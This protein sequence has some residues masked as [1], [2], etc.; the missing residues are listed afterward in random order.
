V[1][2]FQPWK[3]CIN[4]FIELVPNQNSFS[5]FDRWLRHPEYNVLAEVSETPHS[6]DP[7]NPDSI[8]LICSLYDDLLPNFSSKQFNVG[9]D[10]TAQLGEG[11]SSNA[12]AKLG[13]GRVYLNFLK[14][15]QNHVQ[16]KGRTMQF[17][18]DIVLKYPELIP[19]LPTNVIGLIW[20]YEANSPYE[21]RT[22][23]FADAGIAFYVCPGTAAWNSLLGRTDMMR[24]NVN[25]AA[26]YGLQNGAK[27]LMMT[28]WGDHGHWQT[29][30]F[31]YPGFTYAAALSWNFENNK[32]IDLPLALDTHIF[33]DENNVV[34]NIIAELGKVYHIA[35]TKIRYLPTAVLFLYYYQQEADL[36]DD[37]MQPDFVKKLQK[38]I[39]K[40]DVLTAELDNAKM[41]S[42]DGNL[43]IDEI[44]IDAAIAKHSYK[45]GIARIETQSTKI[46]DIPYERRKILAKELEKIIPEYRK[47]WLRRNREGGLKDSTSVFDNLLK[48]YKK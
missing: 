9:C 26:K 3:L 38:S 18:C 4:L 14:K 47:I 40:I 13:K 19:E 30:P 17:W 41:A 27:G 29:L 7:E 22:K 16:K 33:M 23:K 43:I 34:G 20:G 12:V 42:E 15:I 35:L 24:S 21:A 32:N 2:K 25:V 1:T 5:H 48:I 11:G 36:K 10:E 31:A 45:M 37:Y 8:K 44:K 28:E 46:V 6:L 39:D